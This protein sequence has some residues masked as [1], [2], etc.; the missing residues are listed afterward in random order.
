MQTIQPAQLQELVTNATKAG[1]QVAVHAIGDKAVDDVM[2]VFEAVQAVQP[3]STV[4]HRIE[5]VQ[6]SRCWQGCW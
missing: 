6:V 1:L 5:H 2:E 3:A 4:R